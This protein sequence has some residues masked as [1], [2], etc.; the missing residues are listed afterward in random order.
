M[1]NWSSL[2]SINPRFV[3]S[4]NFINILLDLVPHHIYYANIKQDGSKGSSLRNTINNVSP[5]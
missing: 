2:V 3:L 5:I 4:T 1:I